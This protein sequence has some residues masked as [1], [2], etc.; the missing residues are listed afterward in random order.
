[1]DTPPEARYRHAKRTAKN[2]RKATSFSSVPELGG[3]TRPAWL[4]QH[5]VFGFHFA[6]PSFWRQP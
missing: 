5:I 2:R 6:L 4:N 1:M 3:L